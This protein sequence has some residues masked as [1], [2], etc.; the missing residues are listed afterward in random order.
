MSLTDSELDKIIKEYITKDMESIEVPP[1]DQQWAKFKER[2]LLEEK[3]KHRAK[4]AWVAVVLLLFT[5]ITIFRPSEATALGGK[6]IQVF[7]VVVGE[8]SQ[9]IATTEKRSK[10]IETPQAGAALNNNSSNEVTFEEAQKEVFFQIAQPRYLPDGMLLS[11]V[12][13]NE[14]GNSS[15]SVELQ[16][17][18]DDKVITISQQTVMGDNSDSVLYDSEDAQIQQFDLQGKPGSMIKTKNGAITVLWR[19]RGLAFEVVSVL[20][21]DE[22]MKIVQSIN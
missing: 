16:Y 22:I 10:T 1:V 20:P 8:T 7:K 3:S 2:Y 5:G 13:L 12:M 6:F 4:L 9:N 18:L 21:E 19:D 14:L 11:K 15:Y 17:R